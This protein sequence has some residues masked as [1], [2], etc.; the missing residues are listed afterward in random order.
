MMNET[1]FINLI[2]ISRCQLL[3]KAKKLYLSITHNIMYACIMNI[4]IDFYHLLTRKLSETAN[5][6]ESLV[7]YTKY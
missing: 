1:I 4:L 7:K 3:I 2:A 6:H 5:R